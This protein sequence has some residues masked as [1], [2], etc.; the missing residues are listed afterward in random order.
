MKVA[1]LWCRPHPSLQAKSSC[2][3]SPCNG[4]V[5]TPPHHDKE[6]TSPLASF[7]LPFHYLW[8][9]SFC[10]Y[11]LWGV[12]RFLNRISGKTRTNPGDWRHWCV[13]VYMRGGGVMH[14][15]V[16]VYDGGVMRACVRVYLYNMWGGCACV[17][18]TMSNVLTCKNTRQVVW[19]WNNLS[20]DTCV[21]M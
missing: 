15:F 3:N 18:K 8:A 19:I 14:S 7:G 6:Q 12:V 10:E 16:C 2:S 4:D 11:G 20:C 5:L 17:S 13:R 9:I 21:C 1:P